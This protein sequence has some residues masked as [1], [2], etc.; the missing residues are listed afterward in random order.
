MLSSTRDEK[1]CE[2]ITSDMERLDAKLVDSSSTTKAE[3]K[4]ISSGKGIDAFDDKASTK[5]VKEERTDIVPYT[6]EQLPDVE[7]KRFSI[8]RVMIHFES[9]S[10]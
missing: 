8:P 7:G 3:S 6:I 4:D 9:P 1:D 5:D 10:Q 2:K